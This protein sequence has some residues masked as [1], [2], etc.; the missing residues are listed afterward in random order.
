MGNAGIVLLRHVIVDAS[1]MDNSTK[2]AALS[3]KELLH[4]QLQFV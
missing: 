1:E 3:L 4:G 2:W